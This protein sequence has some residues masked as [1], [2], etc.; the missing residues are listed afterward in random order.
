M[1]SVA[2]KPHPES[3]FRK[4]HNAVPLPL[5]NAPGTDSH[6]QASTI[7]LKP[8]CPCDGGCPRCA[9]LIQP[10]P[11]MTKVLSHGTY[12]VADGLRT[13]LDRS[14]GG[15]EGLP[16]ADRRFMERRFGVDFSDVKVH[17]DS[18]A[19][20]MNRE[21]NAQAFTYKKNIYFGA[22]KYAPGI[23]SG[24][25][26]LA[27]ELAHVV[28]SGGS[29]NK[30]R[31]RVRANLVNCGGASP[32][33][34]GG[35]P[36]D[37]IR[38]ADRRAIELLDD[39]IEELQSARRQIRR[40][41]PIDSTTL[42]D[43]VGA[44]LRAQFNLNPEDRT[45]W[46]SHDARS[47]HT[48]IRRFQLTRRMLNRGF[49]RYVCLGPANLTT[50]NCPGYSGPCCGAGVWACACPTTARIYLCQR[51]W[52]GADTSPDMRALTLIHET[53]HIYFHDIADTGVWRNAHRYE[54][55]V[56]NCRPNLP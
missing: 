5:K 52:N 45:I 48:L 30:I 2:G 33:I 39:I 31:R 25:R 26:L 24:K 17:T 46:T 11:M 1:K 4:K 51:W 32:A 22:G 7:Q 12:P 19:D 49:L 9:P 42:S 47:V 3:V 44:Q 6:H 15:G 50:A 27:H 37:T 28:Q 18:N 53:F 16:I 35:N 38:A 36:L 10:K 14:K 13:R 56:A 34:V 43:C 40:G 23:S 29:S 8:I 41:Q 21:L 20:I 55:F 54:Q